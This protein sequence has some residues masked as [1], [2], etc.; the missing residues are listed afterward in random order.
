MPVPKELVMK[1]II[2]TGRLSF[3]AT[4]LAVAFTT[5]CMNEGDGDAPDPSD[6]AA[7]TAIDP[8]MAA[9]M[10]RDLGLTAG[11]VPLLL[12]VERQ[13]V[14]VERS[15]KDRLGNQFAGAW[16]D[17]G[18]RQL[19]V[20]TTDPS[21][22]D[23]I[24]AAGAEVRVMS[25]SLATLQAVKAGLD[26]ATARPA[27]GIHSWH[28]DPATNSVVVVADDP[29]SSQVA[30]F[31]DKVGLADGTVRV[32]AATGERP[33]LLYDTRGGDAYYIDSRFRCSVGFSVNG[34]FVTAGH[35]GGSGSTTAGHNWVAQGTFRG[36]SFPTNDYAWVEVDGS[37][38]TQPDVNN[39]AGGVVH[40][41]GS[42]VAS[43]GSSICRSG[44]TTGWRC[45]LVE[46]LDVT[47]RFDDGSLLYE[48]T[49]TSAC[50]QGG[51]SG[52]SFMSGD[53][54]QGVLSG[55]SGNCTTGGRTFFQP[56]NEILSA[57]GLALK[58]AGVVF[59]QDVDYGGGSSAP[60][61]KGDYPWYPADVPNDWMS[62]LRVP[63]GWTVEAYEHVN[64]GGA[65]C[66][67]SGDTR[68]VGESCNDKMS[69]FR[70]Y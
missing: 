49:Q 54:A 12:A 23:A 60:K 67:F 34:G 65:V 6:E 5:A 32:V 62:S 39:Y 8:A 14:A 2:I 7:Q 48:A 61:G 46:A 9:A 28:V 51:D 19:V 15:L 58:T 33:R 45:G 37:W 18:T 13:A 24:R 64:F 66:T 57:Y 17:E 29:S 52:G 35:C 56:V 11:E 41:A 53:Q 3:V 44:S 36:S 69:S 55:G 16:L 47:V 22:V 20:A 42:Q 26:A 63:A 59:Y 1:R 68:W 10:V 43:I 40:V 27:P 4:C 30:S 70:I 25:R 50:A 31:V 38:N 21:Q